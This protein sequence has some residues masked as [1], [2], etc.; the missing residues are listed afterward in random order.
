MTNRLGFQ[1]WRYSSTVT[2]ALVVWKLQS[3]RTPSQVV[4]VPLRTKYRSGP[5]F[6]IRSPVRK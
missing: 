2:S 4:K 1:A 6:S 3:G 5:C